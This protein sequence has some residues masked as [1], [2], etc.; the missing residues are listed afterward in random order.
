PTIFA[1][2]EEPMSCRIADLNRDTAPDIVTVNNFS[3][4]VSVLL[5]KGDGT[6]QM[7]VPFPA[8]DR[9]TSI[10]VA[11]FD[12]DDI[13]DIAVAND[14]VDSRSLPDSVRLL[15]GNGD[16]TFQESISYY[17][18]GD[19]ARTVGAADLDGDDVLDI[20]TINRSTDD[21]TIL[22]GNG[23]GTFRA[24]VSFAAGEA[25]AS[26]AVGDLDS[27]AVPDL[28]IAN[29]GDFF[30]PIVGDV[31]VLLGNGDG[32][33]RSGTSIAVGDGP[34]AVAIADLDGAD[35]LSSAYV[36]EAVQYRLLDRQV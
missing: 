8:G 24:G 18:V 36:A 30:R 35:E 31:S 1:V 11:D 2:G 17:G 5:G 26:I 23:D 9:P 33:F 7:A 28:M 20:V 13:P 14:H 4:D 15:I 3:D 22:I 25:P 27:D 12:G 16:G 6:F 32:T 34:G 10:A 29:A 19:G 21:A